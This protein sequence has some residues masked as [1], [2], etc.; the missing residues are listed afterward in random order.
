MTLPTGIESLL[1]RWTLYHL[2]VRHAGGYWS[3]A[4]IYVWRDDRGLTRRDVRRTGA[5]PTLE[6]AVADGDR[7]RGE[8][9]S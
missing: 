8:V 1:I 2:E 5:A 3:W 7:A 6:Q 4:L 9:T